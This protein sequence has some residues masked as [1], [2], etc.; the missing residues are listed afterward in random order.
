ML[1]YLK[2][3]NRYSNDNSSAF[4]VSMLLFSTLVSRVETSAQEKNR[5]VMN[6]AKQRSL[7]L[8]LENNLKTW[9][10]VL[11]KQLNLIKLKEIY[12]KKNNQY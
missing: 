3:S 4:F 8:A 5:K 10:I 12:H 7:N 9:K 2:S 1:K 6:W 11:L